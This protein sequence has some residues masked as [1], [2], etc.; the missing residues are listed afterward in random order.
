MRLQL[1]GAAAVAAAAGAL[2]APAAATFP[3]RNGL[4]AY[5]SRAPGADYQRW[6]YVMRPDGS[7]RHP[8]VRIDSAIFPSWSPDGRRIVFERTKQDGSWT[9]LMIVR[10]DGGGLRTLVRHGERP[11]WTPSGGKISY[12]RRAADRDSGYDLW[13]VRPDGS[14]QRRLAHLGWAGRP[15]WSPDGRM[16]A[17]AGSYTITVHDLR[18]GSRRVVFRDGNGGPFD[19][20]WSPDSRRLAFVNG[21]FPHCG[22]RYCPVTRLHTVRPDGRGLTTLLETSDVRKEPWSPSWAPD[23]RVIAYCRHEIVA[24][25]YFT[26]RWTIRPDGTHAHRAARTG[27]DGDWQAQPR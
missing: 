21:S 2:A 17:I 24:G 26:Y 18:D 7:F 20:T 14:H 3:G 5:S 22:E 9:G 4:V 27:C 25:H 23:G 16:A 1:A 13:Q 19:V 6:L 11:S 15:V 10:A 12:I 8:L